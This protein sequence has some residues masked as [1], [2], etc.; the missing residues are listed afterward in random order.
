[1]ISTNIPLPSKS[2]EISPTWSKGM[3]LRPEQ[4][5]RLHPQM[6]EGSTCLGD[7]QRLVRAVIIKCKQ[8]NDARESFLK[9]PEDY[10]LHLLELEL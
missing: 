8:S 9:I 4:T 2:G 1:M 5:M 7:S 6:M 3:L 10:P